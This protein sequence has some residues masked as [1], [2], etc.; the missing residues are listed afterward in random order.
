[1]FITVFVFF[2]SSN[3]VVYFQGHDEERLLLACLS[4]VTVSCIIPRAFYSMLS[5]IMRHF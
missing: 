3:R 5:N 2:N 1:M 4:P